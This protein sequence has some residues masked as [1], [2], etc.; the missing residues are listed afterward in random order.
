MRFSSDSVTLFCYIILLITL[1]VNLFV[2]KIS[3]KKKVIII[4]IICI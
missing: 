3:I 1:Y 4:T 2:Q